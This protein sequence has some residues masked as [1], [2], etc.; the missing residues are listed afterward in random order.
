MLGGITYVQEINEWNW[1]QNQ[2]GCRTCVLQEWK[3]E[4]GTRLELVSCKDWNLNPTLDPESDQ[5]LSLAGTETWTPLLLQFDSDW[6][7]AFKLHFQ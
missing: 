5:N 1:I 4:L 2:T 3:R 6:K 7:M